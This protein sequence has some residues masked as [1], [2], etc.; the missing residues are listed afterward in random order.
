MDLEDPSGLNEVA[1]TAELARNDYVGP[2]RL[3]MRDPQGEVLD[4][5]DVT[6]SASAG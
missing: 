6:V 4:S 1:W 3:E 2:A 5:L